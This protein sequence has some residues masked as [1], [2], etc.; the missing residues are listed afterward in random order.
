M[1][2]LQLGWNVL[3]GILL[4][5]LKLDNIVEWS[6][7]WVTAPFWLGTAFWIL[8]ILIALVISLIANILDIEK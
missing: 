7:V 5:A 1:I 4:V 2:K 6:W 3:L 8:A